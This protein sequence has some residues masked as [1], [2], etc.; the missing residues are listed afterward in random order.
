[1]PSPGRGRGAGPEEAGP[2]PGAGPNSGAGPK[3]RGGRVSGAK[4]TGVPSFAGTKPGA[5]QEWVG[6][7]EEGPS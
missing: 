1:M 4:T 6:P 5:G 2:E 3:R 7:T